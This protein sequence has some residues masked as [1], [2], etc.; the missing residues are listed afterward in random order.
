MTTDVLAGSEVRSAEAAAVAV[1]GAV[2]C[3]A[4]VITMADSATDHRLACDGSVWRGTVSAQCPV[5][6]RNIT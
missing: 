4:K 2:I 1:S 3:D 6:D 5:Q